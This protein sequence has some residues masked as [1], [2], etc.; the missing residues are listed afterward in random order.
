[1]N[2]QVVILARSFKSP[3]E[4]QFRC[5]N[6]VPIPAGEPNIDEMLID[7]SN[8]TKMKPTRPNMVVSSSSMSTKCSVP[9][10]LIDNN[11][12][13]LHCCLISDPNPASSS[14]KASDLKPI[15]YRFRRRGIISTALLLDS[16]GKVSPPNLAAPIAMFGEQRSNEHQRRA[17]FFSLLTIN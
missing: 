10:L 16:G 1:V 14:S 3:L 2:E 15:I 13:P 5:F 11:I 17:L 7:R 4:H 6:I 9:L 8:L 12:H